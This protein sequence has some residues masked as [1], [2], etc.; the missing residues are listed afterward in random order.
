MGG[1]PTDVPAA[2]TPNR[3]SDIFIILFKS[4]S[5]NR[6]HFMISIAIN[7]MCGRMGRLILQTGFN[8]PEIMVAVGIDNPD[9]PDFGKDLGTLAGQEAYG[10]AVGTTIEQPVDV[11][12]DFSSP[13]GT[14]ACLDVCVKESTAMVTGTTGFT[15]AQIEKIRGAAH[16]IPLVLAPNMATG[17]NVMFSLVRRA[18]ELLDAEFDAEIIET[19]HRFKKDAPSGTAKKLVE[20]IALGRKTDS[21]DV[22]FGR[23][24]DTGERRPGEIGVHS[25]RAGDIVG[26]HRVVF[27]TLGESI[28]ICHR[29]HSRRGFARGAIRAAK[30]IAG[31]KPGLYTMFDVLGL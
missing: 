21:P 26:E 24:D 27:S 5:A 19:H 13:E 8:D 10:I 4:I 3:S 25:V 14:M 23:K 12:I 20:M 16:K 17:V 7:G 22:T 11:L 6:E 28:E 30:F 18:A 29:A 2:L 15:D 1:Y 9:N 31:K